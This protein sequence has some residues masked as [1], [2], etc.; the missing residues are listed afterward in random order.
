MP[1]ALEQTIVVELGDGVGVRY[2]GRILAES[3]ATVVR[4][5]ARDTS[6]DSDAPWLD[7]GKQSLALDLASEDGKALLVRLVER[8][9]VLIEDIGAAALS[10]FGLDHDLAARFP[11]LVH[12]TISPFGA[13][14][15]WANRPATDLI[16]SALSGM[17]AINGF[18]D[19]TPL[20][21][22]GPQAEMVAGLVAAIGALAA[23]EDRQ[24][25]GLGQH[26]DVSTLEA[27][28]NVLSP[29]VLQ[30]SYQGKMPPRGVRGAGYL[31]PC[32]D[33]WVS[34]IISADK[35]W[36][37]IVEV[38]GV[39]IDREDPRFATE[40]ARRQHMQEVREAL[41][42]VLMERSRGE[43]F[44]MLAPMRVVCGM[45]MRPDE[46]LEDEHLAARQAFAPVTLP[47]G[48][49]LRIPRVAIRT[50]GEA[51][52]ASLDLHAP[53]SDTALW[54]EAGAAR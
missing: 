37:T 45:V 18:V 5:V 16:V 41:R 42:P 40:A 28:L 8:A 52:P 35:A 20:R 4:V 30:D 7:P 50:R 49:S 36:E 24:V 39:P 32:A 11:R 12:A 10:A 54:A 22:P 48:A 44:H 21:E 15:P 3:G 38:L 47:D 9:D 14:G 1:P 26:V 53:G 25:T 27:M 17:C 31:F 34:L 13:D 46:L 19:G 43:I 2:C 29:T 51:R 23:L 33:G 6:L